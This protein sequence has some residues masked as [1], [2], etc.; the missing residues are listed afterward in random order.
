MVDIFTEEYEQDTKPI[1]KKSWV[2]EL[3]DALEVMSLE[4]IRDYHVEIGTYLKIKQNIKNE[5][6]IAR[7]DLIIY[8]TRYKIEENYDD[9][10]KYR[11]WKKEIFGV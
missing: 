8:M 3:L 6:T 9:I 2:E 4:N 5:Q 1:N 7:I 11:G 10:Q